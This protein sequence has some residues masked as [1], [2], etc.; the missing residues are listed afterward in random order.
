MA[1]KKRKSGTSNKTRKPR[2][3]AQSK[4]INRIKQGLKRA[5]INAKNPPTLMKSRIDGKIKKAVNLESDSLKSMVWTDGSG[6]KMLIQ[7]KKDA[8]DLAD[9]IAE[10]AEAMMDSDIKGIENG[11]PLTLTIEL[12]PND[13]QEA[14]LQKLA[15]IDDSL[16][17][18]VEFIGAAKTGSAF[19]KMQKDLENASEGR[20]NNKAYTEILGLLDRA[21][22]LESNADTLEKLDAITAAIEGIDLRIGN[23]V[24]TSGSKKEKRN[25]ALKSLRGEIAKEKKTKTF[26]SPLF[27]DFQK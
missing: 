18:R 9:N 7:R 11:V 5:E 4:R 8:N 17:G 10:V 25:D 26:R 2:T 1:K 12:G 23:A 15:D 27:R 13:S 20:V 16:P 14:I 22:T 21:I 24:R 19:T 6:K 3:A